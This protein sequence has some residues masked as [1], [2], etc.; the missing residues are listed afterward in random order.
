MT[1]ELR[2]LKDLRPDV[3]P[4]NPEA[5]QAARRALQRAI[6]RDSSRWR[7]WLAPR[8]P[9]RGS[10]LVPLAGILIV[11]AVVAVFLGI[12][13]GSPAVPAAGSEVQLVFRAE[14]T[15]QVPVITPAAMART[16]EIMRGRI[17]PVVRGVT[18]SSAGD[19][20]LVGVGGRTRISPTQLL[21][22]AA[23]AG[24][25]VFYDWEANVLTPSGKPVASLLQT[26]DPS[27][28][29]L[30]QGG[31]SAA[32]GSSGGGSMSLYAAVKLASVQPKRASSDNSRVG[33]EYFMFGAQG[34][35]A[36]GAA[37]SY[38]GTQP[39]ARTHCYLSGPAATVQDLKAALPP[40]VAA[41]AG[42]VLALQQ[43]TVVLEAWAASFS[44]TPILGDPAAQFYVLRDHVALFGNE[45]TNP[46]QSTDATGMPDISVGFT[47]RGQA[48]FQ[49]VTARIAHRG[50][51]VSG[52][53]QMLNQ[54]FAVAIDSR[55][56]TV[57]SI[58]FR[59]YPD[60]ITGTASAD[61]TAGLTK[62]SAKQLAREL[63]LGAF[64]VD[65]ELISMSR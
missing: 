38:Y 32:P 9:V 51:V 7:R 14:P 39:A 5:R 13:S 55:L 47:T 42:E 60:G 62:T 43:G 65:L 27:A 61:V 40:G 25:L 3:R 8:P 15:R 46:R 22:L 30:S 45:I 17:K 53:A 44:R 63:R 19:Q 50:A 23:P 64:P 41:S 36:C 37:A 29:L 28:L 31:G 11:I 34:S 12:R 24:R 49:H 56:I 4:V 10:Q 21:A 48:E 26:Q 20:I 57:P 18:I 58:D 59:T 1:D 16:V 33:P 6:T 54:H 52:F 2:L 35:A